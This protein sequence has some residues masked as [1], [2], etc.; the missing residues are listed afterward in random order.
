MSENESQL[1]GYTLD[2]PIVTLTLNRPEKLNAFSDELVVALNN[3]LRQFDA[4]PDAQIAIIHGN[5]RAFSTGAD[6]HQR[7]LR[8]REEFERLGGP[9]GFGA[10]SGDLFINSVNWK[11]VIT[12]VHGYV[13]GL[14]TGIMLESDLIVAEA[15]TRIQVTETSRGLGGAKYWGLMQYRGGG[16]FGTE[17][18]LT[19]R[20]FS[21]EEAFDAGMINRVA[22]AGEH[23]SVARELAEEVCRNPPLSVRATVRTRRWYMA[24]L[25]REI[26]MQT[27]PL[28]LYL[29]EDFHEAASA[30]AQK[31]K[32][33]PFRGR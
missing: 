17:M 1:V 19:G 25:G 26:G 21:A 2:G 4:D 32:P 12:A 9:Q 29:T 22:P 31:R 30:F 33:E 14:A 11:P 20:F 10:N 5:G 15:G 28:K 23:L 3:R 24:Q 6:V 13:L 16:A 7:Q 18:A 8:S 27:Q